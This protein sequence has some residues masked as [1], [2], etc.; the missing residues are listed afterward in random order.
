MFFFSKKKKDT[1]TA[2][3]TPTLARTALR[4]AFNPEF[5]ASVR[6]LEENKAVFVNL[7]AMI[8]ASQGM[9]PRNH[10]A[11]LGVAGARLGLG[12]LLSLVWKDLTFSKETVPQVLMF[13]A[14]IASLAFA[15]IG[16]VVVILSLFISTAHADS[17]FTPPGG[18]SD[19]G[20]QWINFLFQGKP[21]NT[22]AFGMNEPLMASSK[23]QIALI[24]ALGFYSD[25]ILIVAA[26]ILFYHLASMTVE[27]AHHGVVMG[28]R[29]N[30][31]WAPI[32]LVVAI[33][34]LVPIGGGL[35]SGQ[36][37]VIRVAEW[38]SGLASNVWEIFLTSLA[39]TEG[40]ASNSP[41]ARQVVYN[42][43]LM[44][45]CKSIYNFH[46]NGSAGG[47]GGGGGGG[48]GGVC[49]SGGGG[50]G[51]GGG[52]AGGNNDD[53]S[54]ALSKSSSALGKTIDVR[55]PFDLKG[56]GKKC[57]YDLEKPINQ[58]D[59]ACGSYVFKANQQT[60]GGD[61]VASS[62]QGKVN[63][64]ATS[65]FNDMQSNVRQWVEEMSAYQVPKGMGGKGDKS[66]PQNDG[67]FDEIVNDYQDALQEAAIA[68][69]LSGA[70]FK[71]A[72]QGW[73][74]A[75]AFFNVIARAQADAMDLGNL[76][77][78]TKA[79]ESAKM[80]SEQMKSV[81]KG[82][83]SFENWMNSN[84]KDGVQ[85]GSTDGGGGTAG[86]TCTKQRQE[87]MKTRAGMEQMGNPKDHFME[88]I[89][90]YIDWIASWN[91]VWTSAPPSGLNQSNFTLGVQ[92]TSANPLAEMAHFGHAN[93]NTA[94]DV[95][96]MY[97]NLVLKGSLELTQNKIAGEGA[98]TIDLRGAEGEKIL[99]AIGGLVGAI[100][101][102]FFTSG[103][104]LAF[105]LPLIP[106]FRFLFNIMTWVAGLMEA[107]VCVPLIAL[108]HLNPE[109]D[110]L[111]GPNAKTA[112]Y[113]VFDIFLRP[114]MLIFGLIVGLL[115]FYVAVSYM[116][117]FYMDAIV[118]S[119]GLA[120]GHLFLSRLVYSALYVITLYI[121][122]NSAFKMIHYLPQHA[123]QWMGQRSLHYHQFGDPDQLQQPLMM[124]AGMVESK[125]VGSAGQLASAKGALDVLGGSGGN[126]QAAKQP[127]ALTKK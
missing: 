7:L 56:A 116:N 47:S 86:G 84:L 100:V 83:A 25:A 99:S 77:P 118:T 29:A 38:G 13:F 105:L 119:G 33:G 39:N 90:Q 48:G 75:G 113:F 104:M 51:G 18:E 79:P 122:A 32:R 95:F 73:V 22:F 120:N 43:A 30:Q 88:K 114:T 91:C 126:P 89:F 2:A 44:E 50:S 98:R 6:P 11:V 112:Y 27:T 49:S 23:V 5:G 37:I 125:I 76:L 8:F 94:Y 107:V 70:F 68:P 102:I 40:V 58:E 115:I 52:G 71:S 123:L 54:P 17:Y 117:L 108:A 72:D 85:G 46:V 34:L 101:G 124:G 42:V 61:S 26:V 55:G 65:A 103:I 53:P 60:G 78:E 74:S 28:K 121:A 12:E 14:V 80:N 1:N 127:P 4:V 81:R 19:I 82:L 66:F 64:T 59:G 21:V 20:Q 41:Y 111:P 62:I 31:I 97:V 9:F 16:F 57:L 69:D 96:D 10:P 67:K 110:G 15:V 106:F 3:K 63:S 35:N 92:F 36:Y 109:G 45:A 93:I 87:M 24:H